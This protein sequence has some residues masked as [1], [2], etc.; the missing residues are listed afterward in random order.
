MVG[1]LSGCRVAHAGVGSNQRGYSYAYTITAIPDD[2]AGTT[3][4][5]EGAPCPAIPTALAVDKP[6]TFDPLAKHASRQALWVPNP[7]VNAF[8]G[9]GL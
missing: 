4:T 5:L 1:R 8:A 9:Y 2:S 3:V 6:L 7:P